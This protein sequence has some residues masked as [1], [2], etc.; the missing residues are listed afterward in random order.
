MVMTKAE[1]DAL[2]MELKKLYPG[3]GI[4]SIWNKQT[5]ECVYVGQT[6]RSFG[7]RFAEH[8]AYS[9]D[10]RKTTKI[11][12]YIRAERAKGVRFE[13]RV[14]VNVNKC[15]YEYDLNM[16]EYTMILKYKQEG[17]PLQNVKMMKDKE[18]VKFDFF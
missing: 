16:M 13:F 6:T 4:Y 17:H 10:E 8:V 18:P 2:E 15:Y 14:E 12:E 5:G 11:Y 9:W 3:R 7:V 1:R